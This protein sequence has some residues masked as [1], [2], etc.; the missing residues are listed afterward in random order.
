MSEFASYLVAVAG[1]FTAIGG[2]LL[3]GWK[4]L[5]PWA[6]LMRIVLGE[7]R[8]DGTIVLGLAPQMQSLS[9]RQEEHGTILKEVRAFVGENH[10]SYD[11]PTLP[12]RISDLQVTVEE[13]ADAQK[14][15]SGIMQQ[16]HV[17]DI[18]RDVEQDKRLGKIEADI[19][20]F[21]EKGERGIRDLQVMNAQLSGRFDE[22]VRRCSHG[23]DV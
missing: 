12:D 8:Q 23:E 14:E 22:H 6:Q 5:K 20:V 19:A 15:A 21:T 3:L 13:L 16:Y 9:D 10:H 7:K 18:A 2:A 17:E 4:W 1:G 11:E